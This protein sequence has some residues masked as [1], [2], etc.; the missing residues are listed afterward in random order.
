M[1][2]AWIQQQTDKTDYFQFLKQEDGFPKKIEQL[3]MEA[4]LLYHVPFSYLVPDLDMLPEESVQFFSVDYNWVLAYMDGICSVGRNAG[5]DYSH[6]TE[7]LKQIYQK[8]LMGNG[9][10]RKKLQH[11][12]KQEDLSKSDNGKYASGFL[13]H[14]VLVEDFR[15]IEFRAYGDSEGKNQLQPLRIEK[16][17]TQILLGIFSGRIC[18]LEFVQPPEGLHYGFIHTN[19]ERYKTLRNVETGEL[20]KKQV[21]ITM[22][23]KDSRTLNIES[24]AKDMGTLLNRNVT[25]VDMGL[26][27]IQNALTGVF[28]MEE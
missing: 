13:L 3:L 8:V 23:E 26:Q 7:L 18:R 6:D 24:L 28:V 19:I 20:G 11:L 17:G 25:S 9:E 15:G 21:P 14:S 10:I 2:K 22:R 12:E 5:I 4:S 27:M 1:R 16:L